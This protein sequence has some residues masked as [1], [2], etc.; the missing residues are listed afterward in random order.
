MSY[1]PLIIL[2]ALYVGFELFEI[3]LELI[4]LRCMKANSSKVPEELAGDVDLDLLEKT[5]RYTEEKT[6]F[7][8]FTSGF[9][10]VIKLIFIFSGLM[11][12]YSQWINGWH[13]GFVITGLVFFILISLVKDIIDIPFDIY[14]TFGIEK[15]FGFN[16]QTPKIWLL[17]QLKNQ[18]L[19][20][21]FTVI[22]LGGALLLIKYLPNWWWIAAWGF[23]FIFSLFVMYISPY[24][25]EPLFNKFTPVEDE[26]L[27]EGISKVLDNAD[28]KVKGVFKMDAS[29]R[30]SH[31]NAYFTGIGKVKRI[32]L[33]DTLME[34]LDND[35]IIAVLAH[36]AGHCKKKHI[37][38]MLTMFEI[39]ALA[40]AYIAF[41]ILGSQL[42]PELFHIQTDN[43]FVKLI[44]LS[45]AAGVILK[46]VS[47]VG[48]MISRKFEW[49]ADAFAKKIV[50]G[51]EN[52]ATALIK[53]SKDNLS[54]L[55]P[56][57]LF[58]WY[59]YSHPPVLERVRKLRES[60]E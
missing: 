44:L 30:T 23:F 53:L 42:L 56:H 11:L 35:E 2:L 33:Y 6:R 3:W 36:E 27:V 34:K 7:G 45:F 21:V 15:R 39:I 24:V 16:R 29:K 59:H 4:N 13:L 52:L 58:A 55:Y 14:G 20:I 51:G 5:G 1:L 46:P 26:E 31:T 17:D 37:I 47:P 10:E 57:P 28:I 25:L 48:S 40:G 32:V 60:A 43:F 9:D 22:L 8:L 49:E 41:A 54:N 18:L 50:G 38:K 19:G 12:W